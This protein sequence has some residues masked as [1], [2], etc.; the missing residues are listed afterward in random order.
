MACRASVDRS[1]AAGMGDGMW[2]GCIALNAKRTG[3]KGYDRSMAD[4]CSAIAP[5]TV[6]EGAPQDLRPGAHPFGRNASGAH[7][8]RPLPVAPGKNP[9]N[10]KCNSALQKNSGVEIAA[11]AP[12]GLAGEQ[13]PL[14]A[15][16]LWSGALSR[17]QGRFPAAA[18]GFWGRSIGSA[19]RYG[20]TGARTDSRGRIAGA[21]P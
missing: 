20:G 14:A 8:T 6:A 2:D 1:A 9:L 7:G 4:A 12:A 17:M 21:E 15:M 11:R 5:R 3:S 10:R 19:V 13:K 18:G 16:S